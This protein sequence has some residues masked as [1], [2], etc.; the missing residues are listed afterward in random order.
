MDALANQFGMSRWAVLRH[1]KNHVTPRR[2]AEL[3]AGPARVNDLV[4]VAASE[5]KGLLEYLGV[6]RGVLFNQFLSAAEAQ[7]G[8]GVAK[9]AS[10]LLESLRELGRITGE[11]RQLSGL[12]INQT[13]VNNFIGSPEFNQIIAVTIN[14]LGEFPEA[15]T[16]FGPSAERRR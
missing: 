8:N 3:L 5:S 4:N 15:R 12:T 14:A 7:D 16:S 11:F 9:I 6:V 10:R 2:K 1:C 13:T